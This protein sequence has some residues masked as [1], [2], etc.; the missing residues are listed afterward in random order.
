MNSVNAQDYIQKPQPMKWSRST[1]AEEATEKLTALAKQFTQEIIA[2]AD[3]RLNVFIT[4]DYYLVPLVAAMTDIKCSKSDSSKWLN[5]EAGL[6]IILHSDNTFES[7][8]IRC[9]SKG[10]M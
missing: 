5:Y 2:L 7:F 1:I 4:H 9:K 3:K 6:G 8:P 10:Y